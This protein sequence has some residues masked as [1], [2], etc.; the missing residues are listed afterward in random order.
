MSQQK[1]RKKFISKVLILT[2]VASMWSSTFASIATFGVGTTDP[3]T[4]EVQ[5]EA[6]DFNEKSEGDN[7]STKIVD[8]EITM[9][10]A[11]TPGTHV[12][13]HD[14]DFGGYT[15]SMDIRLALKSDFPGGKIEIWLDSLDG[16]KI[17][18]HIENG[19][20]GWTT[21][22][23]RTVNLIP[24]SGVHHVVLK[25]SRTPDDPN[26]VG[27]S[28]I[29][30][31]KFTPEEVTSVE[32]NGY[33][34][35]Y[36]VGSELQLS[37]TGVT[38][39]A[40]EIDLTDSSYTSFTS[41][42]NDVISVGANGTLRAIGAGTAVIEGYF[43]RNSLTASTTE[44]TAL[45]FE[46]TVRMEAE[47][48][49][50]EASNAPPTEGTTDVDGEKN[51]SSVKEGH[52]TVY[53]NVNFG[54][55]TASMDLRVAVT[56][57]AA[58]GHIELWINDGTDTAAKVGQLYM[59]PDEWL[60][61]F[62]EGGWSDWKTKTVPLTGASGI[63]D[64]TLKFKRYDGSTKSI[65]NVNWFG[66][67][68]NITQLQLESI[69]LQSD[70]E[71]LVIGEEAKIQLSGKVTDDSAAILEEAIINF[72]S[73]DD[74]VITVDPTGAVVANNAGT[75]TVTAN[76]YLYNTEKE[77]QIT[78]TVKS[79]DSLVV[80]ADN[81][82]AGPGQTVQL[83][84]TGIYADGTEEDITASNAVTYSSSDASIATVNE[85][86]LIT[87]IENGTVTITVIYASGSVTKT[88]T[89]DFTIQNQLDKVKVS[90]DGNLYV[91]VL[92]EGKTSAQ[93]SVAGTM[94]NG[95]AADLTGVAIAYSSSNEAAATVDQAGKVA[96]V[97]AGETTITAS[98]TMDGVTQTGE[99]RILVVDEEL[100]NIKTRLTYH[101]DEARANA[102]A[103]IVKYDWAKEQKDNVVNRADDILLLG[104]DHLWSLVPPQ[105]LPRSLCVN[106]DYDSPFADDGGITWYKWKI[107]PF[108][109]NNNP[110]QWKVKDPVSNYIFPTNDFESYY[111]SGINA[112]GIFD[113]NL[114]DPQYL[115]NT[116]YPEHGES[117]GVDDGYGWT[118]DSGKKWTFIAYYN[119]WTYRNT[120]NDYVNTLE[121]AYLLTGDVQYGRAGAVILDRIAD[122][123]PSLDLFKWH[124]D[125]GF[126]NSHGMTHQ[127]KMIGAQWEPITTK[128]WIKAYD[129]FYPAMGDSGTIDFL[130]QK[131]Q[132]YK[133]NPKHTAAAIRKNIED[134]IIINTLDAVKKA[135]LSGGF[136]RTQSLLSLAATILDDPN[137]D[138]TNNITLQMLNFVMQEGTQDIPV[139]NGRYLTTGGNLLP[140]LLKDFDRD[141]LPP[142]MAPNYNRNWISGM[143]EVAQVLGGYDRFAT[144]DLFQ[145]P[146][147]KKSLYGMSEHTMIGKYNPSIGDSN[148][149][150]FPG[151]SAFMNKVQLQT[152]FEVYGE[153]KFAQALYYVNG[154]SL[155]GINGSIFDEDPEKLTQDIQAVIDEHGIWNLESKHLTGFG[156][157]TLRDGDVFIADY[158]IQTH[159]RDLTIIDSGFTDSSGATAYYSSSDALQFQAVKENENDQPFITFEFNVPAANTYDVAITTHEG[160][161]YGIYDIYIDNVKVTTH[162]FY[163]PSWG[164]GE[165]S[166]AD[167]ALSEG[168]HTIKFVNVGKNDN[169]SGIK[170]AI[171]V[172]ELLTEEDK[173]IKEKLTRSDTRRDLWMYYGRHVYSHAHYDQLN[174]DL[175]AYGMDL[176]PDG[177]YPEKTVAWPKSTDWEE[178]TI[179]HNSV[180]V[181]RKKQRQTP[182]G[183][184]H[185]FE[186][187]DRV[188][189]VD[190]SQDFAYQ[191]T[192][193]YRRTTAMIKVDDVH[194]YAVDFFRV[195]GG[196]EHVFS[197]HGSQGTVTTEG[198]NL[199][200]QETGTYAGPDVAYEQKVD[201]SGY[202][203]LFNVERDSNP[204]SQY[205]V[206][207]DIEDFRNTQTHAGDVH[208]KLTMMGDYSEV[209]LAD[210]VPPRLSGNPKTL[211]YVLVKNEGENVESAY[212]SVMEPYIDDRYIASIE[213]A[214][215]TTKTGEVVSDISV[216]AIKVT[217][218]NGRVDYIVSALD[219]DKQY[220]INDKI[221]FQGA[222][223]VY[224]E[225][226]D[227]QEYGFVTE[228]GR[229][230]RTIQPHKEITG[231]I[232][233]FTKELSLNNEIIVQLDR[234]ISDKLDTLVGR[235]VSVNNNYEALA[236]SGD[237][238]APNGVYSVISAQIVDED[239]KIYALNIG[240]TTL[241][242][243]FV[244]EGDF[245]QGYLFEIAEEDTLTIHFANEKTYGK[246]DGEENQ[247]DNDNEDL[248]NSDGT[249]NDNS[250]GNAG[251]E[252]QNGANADKTFKLRHQESKLDGRSTVKASVDEEDMTEALQG[253]NG[254]VVIFAIETESDA[255]DISVT[256]NQRA[257][258]KMV[259]AEQ[260]ISMVIDSKHGSYSVPIQDLNLAQFAT[261]LE[262]VEEDIELEV[263]MNVNFNAVREAE[264]DGLSALAALDFEVSAK[265]SDNKTKIISQFSTYVPRSIKV[266]HN[267]DPKNLAAVRVVTVNGQ[268]VYHPVPT[269][270]K[271]NE[272]TINSTTNSTYMLLNNDNT[273]SDI[274]KHWGKDHIEFLANKFI[275]KGISAS[276]YAPNQSLT[277]AQ[278]AT[279]LIKGL[280]LEPNSSRADQ[281]S[282]V[283]SKD[284]F[285]NEVGTAVETGLISGYPNGT[286][287]PNQK[288]SRQEMAVMVNNA[289][290]FAQYNEEGT[291]ENVISFVDAHAMDSWSQQA[292]TTVAM[293]GILEG[294]PGGSFEPDKD[295][296][297]A[298]GA[299]VIKRLLQ[300]LKFI[301]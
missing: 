258:K 31:L 175:Y 133:L 153:P 37:F 123:Y 94:T 54:M 82:S 293:A 2:L 231:S 187:T 263:L 120:I 281:F 74:T 10:R 71:Q 159:F 7:P 138:E 239:A 215:V 91:L 217:L 218:K 83:Q 160:T 43:S 299:V 196:N 90:S 53:K 253:R 164:P 24:T 150:A 248:D 240:A 136:G 172:L 285:F 117:W 194:S 224:S 14:V 77:N 11:T 88:A 34:E 216:K 296:T 35:Q 203:W 189:L 63:Q 15:D 165:I 260:S 16:T 168:S 166:L 252:N 233:G 40:K 60:V 68:R 300:A 57:N 179:S 221:I 58:G 232:V 27:A 249:E 5:I 50:P 247:T 66:F 39:N 255:S 148:G 238:R 180:V 86:G 111:K 103:N 55:N 188:K 246:Q 114:A 298:Q 251:N 141:G 228:Q 3:V 225:R 67:T 162:D 184:P 226:D 171:K 78:F 278:F 186:A 250:T 105:S 75:A 190:V 259:D 20:G 169:S 163:D 170:M 157:S 176:A 30:W 122:I 204:A 38:E 222:F 289:L 173:V 242:K 214:R 208:L 270:V 195:K 96:A 102:K 134:G 146:K 139:E 245:S 107:N 97:A 274:Q 301:N 288:I 69:T 291:I 36:N 211:R 266:E 209:A 127:G 79:F 32:L 155:E 243:G 261:E 44:I 206:D 297:R 48:F 147:F 51:L 220:T 154:N 183:L 4:G 254:R 236:Q 156:L 89:L 112:D 52:F 227:L 282:D 219:K 149:V 137:Q 47:V 292:V 151:L 283:S 230:G 201:S 294:M 61:A 13:Y 17:G 41:S 174:I 98:V 275:V 257:L 191:E 210:G 178:N 116:L 223:G 126:H 152:A 72:S 62:N 101:S 19:T 276:A 125:D 213:A 158:G 161:S 267:V 70:K 128:T 73:S 262:A 121:D 28:N 273:F 212:T 12:I 84:V 295:T 235:F 76:V 118:D 29:D 229:I 143:F 130:S 277:R 25:F 6:E 108:D 182:V 202:Q 167:I 81:S 244:N 207:W 8:S 135:Q 45:A 256:F 131:S 192:D 181:D 42:N 92:D 95:A 87:A 279:L 142:Q 64:L 286:F 287:K 237:L 241:V 129:T 106:W 119:H 1:R 124:W 140:R 104:L 46:Q 33:S 80:H 264:E 193:I 198:L 144:V 265:T 9:L 234:S 93:L 109:E 185:H 56:S 199:T 59:D 21:F 49:D 113:R 280:G 26:Q 65:A 115:V 145:N 268:R 132:Q 200:A 205:S 110:M 290:K 271:E 269:Y 177:G 100:M 18:E 23:T 22:E 99:W 85:T 284:W 197:F 272:V